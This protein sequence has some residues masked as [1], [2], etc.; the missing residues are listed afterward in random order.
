MHIHLQAI[1]CAALS[2]PHTTSGHIRVHELNLS[3]LLRQG[4]ML[5]RTYTISCYLFWA[6]LS[7]GFRLRFFL[8]LLPPRSYYSHSDV[9][10]VV[11]K[12]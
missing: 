11:V 5:A 4:W 7:I 6:P 3:I 8:L 1:D 12:L 2:A 10:V 9:V